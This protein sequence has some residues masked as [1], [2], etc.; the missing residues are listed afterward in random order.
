MPRNP[1][2]DTDH[3]RGC[4]SEDLHSG[5]YDAD[6]Y[7]CDGKQPTPGTRWTTFCNSCG[8]DQAKRA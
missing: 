3:C 8:R 4:G 6:D 1:A 5:F 7:A 2:T